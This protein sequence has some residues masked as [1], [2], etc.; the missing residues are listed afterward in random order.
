M[1]AFLSLG[2]WAFSVPAAHAYIDPG[3]GSFI[4]QFAVA[5]VVA[6]GLFLK[7]FW[8]RIRA[9]VARL[10][11]RKQ[12]LSVEPAVTSDDDRVAR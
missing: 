12:A 9:G 10:F 7:T 4:A 11:G 8:H 6:V 1:V 5:G 3:S 2:F